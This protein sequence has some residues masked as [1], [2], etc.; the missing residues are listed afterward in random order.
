LNQ[1]QTKTPQAQTNKQTNKQT[2]FTWQ[3]TVCKLLLLTSLQ[4]NSDEEHL[5]QLSN[6]NSDQSLLVHRALHRVITDLAVKSL[7]LKLIV[8]I[9]EFSADAS[10]ISIMD[11]SPMQL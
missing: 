2:V 9:H 1:D 6:V 11:S 7:Y 10:A 8:E 3:L 5:G 4:N